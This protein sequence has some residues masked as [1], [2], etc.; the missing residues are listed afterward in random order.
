MLQG[1][2]V[3]LCLFLIVLLLGCAR[4]LSESQARELLAKDQRFAFPVMFQGQQMCDRQPGAIQFLEQTPDSATA[5]VY[6]KVENNLGRGSQ[7]RSAVGHLPAMSGIERFISNG[8][9]Y[10][11]R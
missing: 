4:G 5:R 6:R 8:V 2:R 7:V 11:C 3:P 1:R 9:V 10:A